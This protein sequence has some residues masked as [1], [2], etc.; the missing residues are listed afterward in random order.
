MEQTDTQLGTPLFVNKSTLDDKVFETFMTIMSR[1]NDPV[2]R[3]LLTLAGMSA[4]GMAIFQLVS[5]GRSMLVYAIAL[6]AVGCLPILYAIFG[7]KWRFKAFTR[8]QK[9]RWSGDTLEKTVT[10]YEDQFVQQSELGEMTFSYKD[11]TKFKID[12]GLIL[13]WIGHSVL[14]MGNDRFEVGNKEDFTTFI[15]PFVQQN[16][17]ELAAKKEQEKKEAEE[18]KKARFGK[19]TGKSD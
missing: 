4:F 5:G 19:K 7:W 3:I 18:K 12:R 11:I 17:A 14:L 15:E 8:K 10:F 13:L 9:I 1:G 16:Q 6:F 2:P